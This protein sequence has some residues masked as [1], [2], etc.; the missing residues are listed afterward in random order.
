MEDISISQKN[1]SQNYVLPRSS[2]TSN[3]ALLRTLFK[4]KKLLDEIESE[5][6]ILR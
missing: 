1:N 5:H 2:W 6:N 4:V 3:I